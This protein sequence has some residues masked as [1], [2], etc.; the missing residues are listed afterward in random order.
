MLASH[1]GHVTRKDS[2]YKIKTNITLLSFGKTYQNISQIPRKVFRFYNCVPTTVARQNYE[3]E[4]PGSV[5]SYTANFSFTN[6]T[7]ENSMYLPI[8]QIIAT[9]KSS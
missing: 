7:V 9:A 2:R 1:Y 8:P 6:Y 5:T 4:E 3:Y